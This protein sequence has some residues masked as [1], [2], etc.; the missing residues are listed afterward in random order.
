MQGTDLISGWRTKVLHR[1]LWCNKLKN[2]DMPLYQGISPCT[3]IGKAFQI[4]HHNHKWQKT[5]YIE[6]HQEKNKKTK[7]IYLNNTFIQMFIQKEL[8]ATQKM[9]GILYKSCIWEDLSPDYMEFLQLKKIK[10]NITRNQ[11]K[12]WINIS[13]MMW[14]WLE[15][16]KDSQLNFSSLCEVRTQSC[17]TLC[18]FSR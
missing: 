3:W 8:K 2:E 7:K 4:C 15:T 18:D 12:S 16:G 9:G 13:R 1:T 17:L 5:K 11:Q 10:R 6:L 14:H